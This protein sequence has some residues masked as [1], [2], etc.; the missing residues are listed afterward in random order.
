MYDSPD[1]NQAGDP[2]V[3]V[4]FLVLSHRNPAISAP[5]GFL[6]PAGSSRFRDGTRSGRI[7]AALQARNG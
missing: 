3:T 1:E 4:C 2:V 5:G 7:L 6:S